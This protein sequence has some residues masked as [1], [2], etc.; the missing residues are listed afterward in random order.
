[1]QHQKNTTQPA[2]SYT[3]AQIT[4]VAAFAIALLSAL[5]QFV[6]IFLPDVFSKWVL[7]PALSL[8]IIGVVVGLIAS[9]QADR[10]HIEQLERE[11][12]EREEALRN[13]Q[14]AREEGLF[15]E[16]WARRITVWSVAGGLTLGIFMYLL[17]M[18]KVSSLMGKSYGERM[19]KEIW[20]SKKNK[21]N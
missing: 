1:M 12:R 21:H 18:I 16:K 13:E 15:N 19:M 20:E 3:V 17:A 14:H 9:R 6:V 10:E 8:S 2:K 7:A 5:G 11:R 4:A